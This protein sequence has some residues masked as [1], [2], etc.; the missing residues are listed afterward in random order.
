[1]EYCSKLT[2]RSGSKGDKRISKGNMVQAYMSVEVLKY[3]A[4]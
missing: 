4:E 1:V 3:Y 2:S